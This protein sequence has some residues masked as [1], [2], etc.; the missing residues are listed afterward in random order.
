MAY[1]PNQR[2][3]NN[4]QIRGIWPFYIT[5]LNPRFF[6]TTM[7]PK[8]FAQRSQTTN[9]DI[10]DR[11]AFRTILNHATKRLA[12]VLGSQAAS[13]FEFSE[14]VDN[15]DPQF[16]LD[17]LQTQD[18]QVIGDE[19]ARSRFVFD[20]TINPNTYFAHF[21]HFVQLTFC[22]DPRNKM[23]AGAI[24]LNRCLKIAD[25]T[26]YARSFRETLYMFNL[27]RYFLANELKKVSVVSLLQLFDDLSA[28]R[29]D[30]GNVTVK[31]TVKQRWLEYATKKTAGTATLSSLPFLN[32][33][34]DAMFISQG[35]MLCLYEE[36]R[37]YV[38]SKTPD[39]MLATASL[40]SPCWNVRKTA[41]SPADLLGLI[42]HLRKQYTPAPLQS[43]EDIDTAS[44]AFDFI[45][46]QP[47]LEDQSLWS[48]IPAYEITRMTDDPFDDDACKTFLGDNQFMQFFLVTMYPE[49]FGL[50]LSN[51]NFSPCAE[52]FALA[53]K[54]AFSDPLI[55]A[56]VRER[57]N[58]TICEANYDYATFVNAR[59]A[60]LI[61]KNNNPTTN[62][63]TN[64]P[65]L[66][67]PNAR[68]YDTY[69]WA[70]VYNQAR[71]WRLRSLEEQIR[72]DK[73]VAP[74]KLRSLMTTLNNLNFS[75]TD[76]FYGLPEIK[77][78]VRKI[79]ETVNMQAWISELVNTA[80]NDDQRF[81]KSKERAYLTTGVIA[82][83]IFGL[84]DFF[85]CVYT[86]T[87][88]DQTTLDQAIKDPQTI[89]FISIGTILAL[90]LVGILIM[91]GVY[92]LKARLRRKQT[93][94]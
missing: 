33:V 83:G 88:V 23:L 8:K 10:A 55:L 6:G 12:C 26:A 78:I 73:D 40:P 50:D 34:F 82:A 90:L 61:V 68:L 92:T 20:L 48:P 36:L 16:V 38:Q 71:A 32:E 1:A 85:T 63:G 7:L 29:D 46:H 69:L 77:K 24:S 19:L 62:D 75:E 25:D 72:I 91:V 54:I 94:Q 17:V 84:L 14:R 53:D 30:N 80:D 4:L 49:L 87:A 2:L 15:G 47:L 58:A 60:F 31:A 28:Q 57:G 56:S 35:I 74:W 59:Q 51:T 52:A 66:I 45:A 21:A 37:A 42:M 22:F 9:P 43:L 70:I 5:G 11:E 76:D 93:E 65:D 64:T 13:F 81:G 67:D 86:V 41:S 18:I 44:A 3:F 79:D 27:C 89:A 39:K